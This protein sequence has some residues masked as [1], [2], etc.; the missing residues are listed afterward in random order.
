MNTAIV[1][2]G[3]RSYVVS[4]AVTSSELAQGLS[5]TQSMD[6]GAGMLFDLGSTRIVTVNAYNMLFPLSVV[7]IDDNLVVTEVI[8]LDPGPT[9]DITNTIPARYF[10]E[11]NQ[12]DVDEVVVG[13][14]LVLAT[15]PTADTSLLGSPIITAVLAIFL[16]SMMSKSVRQVVGKGM[17]KLTGRKP[18][19]TKRAITKPYIPED[20]ETK[21]TNLEVIGRNIASQA[22]VTF[23][24]LDSGWEGR[25]ITP[26]YWFKTP[27][28]MDIV[29]FDLEEL[30]AK[31]SIVGGR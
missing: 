3:T 5:G 8:N 15:T 13:E 23:V 25:Y 19:Q 2:I 10:L 30:Q 18:A 24:K 29:V 16:I 20:L 1:T 11:V 17:V 26:R 12:G 21:K 14:Q 31:L 22:G 9:N 7:F 6:N 27:G 28:G 4:I